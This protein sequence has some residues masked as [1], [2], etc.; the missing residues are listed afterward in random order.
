[1]IRLA[2]RQFRPSAITAG[3]AL[4]ALVVVA[5]LTGPNLAHLYDTSGI[6]TCNE[7]QDCFQLEAAFLL[8]DAF[9][10]ALLNFL[11]LVVPA[12]IGIFFGA[13]LVARE[14]ETGTYRL[15][16]AQSVSRSRWLLTKFAVVGIASMLCAAVV[17]ITV[18][19]W[20]SPIDRVN[21]SP[22]SIFDHRDIAPVAYAAFAFSLGTLLGMVFRRV[23]PAM[24]ATLA[25][26]V[27]LRLVVYHWLR[28]NLLSPLHLA[29][30]LQVDFANGP[31]PF[32]QG[33]LSPADWV[34]SDQTINAT[35]HV[36]GANG[37]IGPNGNMGLSVASNG[38]A[39]IPGA[40]LCHGIK[41][42]NVAQARSGAVPASVQADLRTCVA[43]LHLRELLAYQP[44]GRYW[45]FQLIES[46]IFIGAAIVLGALCVWW[47]RN[48]LV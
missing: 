17:S 45:P 22:F 38:Q 34:F 47:I 26:Y 2:V 42:S 4:A 13:P 12:L 43:S 46:G 39:S 20:S 3:V 8:N 27:A 19:W 1:V 18:T 16:W 31:D 24:A 9:L 5:L 28:P 7:H 11:V 23:L 40:G 33:V 25:G 36:I 30:G 32:T 6:S 29:T 37:G 21:M 44:A 41:I 35:G 48:R 10:E 14:L 15:A